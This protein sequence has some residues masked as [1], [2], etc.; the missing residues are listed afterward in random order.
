M[1]VGKLL[2]LLALVVAL[3]STVANRHRLRWGEHL[4]VWG[5][6]ALHLVYARQ[7]DPYTIGAAR[8]VMTAFP[9]SVGLALLTAKL[10][11]RW[12]IPLGA[13]ALLLCALGAHTFGEARFEIG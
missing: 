6:L 3:I 8:Y 10:P 7:K 1:T 11:R 5:V 4:I 13:V 2:S 12:Q 9:F